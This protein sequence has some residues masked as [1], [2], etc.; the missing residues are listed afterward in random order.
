MFIRRSGEKHAPGRQKKKGKHKTTRAARKKGL[1]PCLSWQAGAD[2]EVAGT[3][4]KGEPFPRL[5]PPPS[6][7]IVIHPSL[8]ICKCMRVYGQRDTERERD[9]ERERRSHLCAGVCLKKVRVCALLTCEA[10]NARAATA[11]AAAAGAIFDCRLLLMLLVATSSFFFSLSHGSGAARFSLAL[12]PAERRPGTP[13]LACC[14]IFSFLFC[15][16]R[17]SLLALALS[18]RAT[19]RALA[20]EREQQ[21]GNV[22][23]ACAATAIGWSREALIHLCLIYLSFRRPLTAPA[24]TTRAISISLSP[25]CTAAHRLHSLTSPS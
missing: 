12:P 8:S 20:D 11:A 22:R 13:L 10:N 23:R 4:R 24:T 15:L 17:F 5:E 9:S 16:P 7:F 2:A 14:F 25:L 21:G 18:P 1:C 19:R 6:P 3:V